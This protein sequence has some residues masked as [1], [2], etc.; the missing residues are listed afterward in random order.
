MCQEL[1]NNAIKHAQA[2]VVEVRLNWTEDQ[3]Q[4]SVADNGRGIEKEKN[5]KMGNGFGNL[6]KRAKLIGATFSLQ[7]EERKGT[8][9]LIYFPKMGSPFKLD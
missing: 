6:H 8:E 7:T 3:L 2:S 4:L 1:L 5:W 9:A